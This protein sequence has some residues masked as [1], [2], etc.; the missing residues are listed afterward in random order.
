[1]YLGTTL[2]VAA[3]SVLREPVQALNGLLLVGAGLPVYALIRRS[4]PHQG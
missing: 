1:V 3:A 2:A 4:R